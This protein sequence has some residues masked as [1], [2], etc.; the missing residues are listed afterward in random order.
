MIIKRY[1]PKYLKAQVKKRIVV[2]QTTAN[3]KA[4]K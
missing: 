4:I 3:T 2:F 1:D